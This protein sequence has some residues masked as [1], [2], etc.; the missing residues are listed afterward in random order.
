MRRT[1]LLAA[2]ALVCCTSLVQ[3][4][5]ANQR[6][7]EG[8]DTLPAVSGVNAKFDLA[9]F[10]AD[11]S[12][13]GSIAGAITFPLDHSF[14]LQIDGA[15]LFAEDYQM[16]GIAGHLFWRD[17][18]SGL[19]GIYS[20]FVHANFDNL[21]GGGSI[22]G[23]NI[24]LDD[25]IPVLLAAGGAAGDLD[26]IT[27]AL[28]VEKYW[29]EW[30]FEGLLGANIV[31][32]GLSIDDSHLLAQ[33][34]LAY[35]FTDDFRVDAGWRYGI[36]GH[37]ASLGGEWQFASTDD[38]GYSGYGRVSWH[39]GDEFSA[40]VGLRLFVFGDRTLI[41]RHRQ[42][43]PHIH[44]LSEFA[45]IT[46]AVN[47]ADSSAGSAN[48]CPATLNGAPF[49]TSGPLSSRYPRVVV[50][51]S[52]FSTRGA[53]WDAQVADFATSNGGS[54][55]TDYTLDNGTIVAVNGSRLFLPFPIQDNA[56]IVQDAG[57][58][59]GDVYCPYGNQP[60]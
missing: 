52:E 59:I 49:N 20:S 16:Y 36:A 10:V 18:Q 37:S 22:F 5:D 29:N 55:A 9:G 31:D 53:A 35:Y 17:P 30:T 27:L 14:G 11:S 56:T 32:S 40:N 43:D 60:V 34:R 42:D 54:G 6:V 8:F 51:A 50:P 24:D 33:A 47:N 41:E 57:L 21:A 7:D 12:S 26:V 13:A 39:E 45:D 58:G 3:A 1:S 4:Q 2:T 46:V 23:L 15:G 25:P 28:E 48:S 19:F 44:L 38:M